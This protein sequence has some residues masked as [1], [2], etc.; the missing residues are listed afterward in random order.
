MFE[1]GA[2]PWTLLVEFKVLF[3]IIIITSTQ[4]FFVVAVIK[5]KISLWHWRT[6]EIVFLPLCGHPV[7]T[8]VT[9][10]PCSVRS[11][12]AKGQNLERQHNMF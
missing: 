6:R 11:S 2:L 4:Y 1:A 10:A 12:G 8:L 3:Q 5:G 7:M 9:I